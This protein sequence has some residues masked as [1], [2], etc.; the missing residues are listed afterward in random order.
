M[1]R[2]YYLL[3]AIVRAQ[4]TKN[5]RTVSGVASELSADHFADCVASGDRES[6]INW[7]HITVVEGELAGLCACSSL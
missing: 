7:L 3:A 5:P 1:T 2:T 4:L 6:S